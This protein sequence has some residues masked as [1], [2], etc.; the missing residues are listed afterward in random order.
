MNVM[1]VN[2]YKELL[3]GLN[4][5]VMKSIEGVFNVDEIIDTFTNFY[6]DKMILDITAIRDYQNTDNL[7][8]L[9]MNIN[10][11]NVILLLDDSPETATKSYLSKL[12]SLGIYNFTRNAEGINYLLVH[13]HTYRDVVNIHNLEDLDSVTNENGD[14]IVTSSTSGKMKIIGFKNMTQHAGATTLIYL[15]RKALSASKMVGAIEVNKVDFLYFNDKD[16]VSTTTTELPKELM[17]KQLCD[18]VFVDLNDYDDVSICAE[19]YYLIEPSTIMINK[20]LRKNKSV[21][22]TLKEEK[23]VLNKCVLNSDDVSTFE[24]ETKLKVFATIPPVDDRQENIEA[25]NKFISKMNL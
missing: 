16:L 18:V 5:E 1:V 6:Y 23:V 25:I 7:Q 17:K 9:A 8:K 24:Y 20:M 22:E 13:P 21:L 2:K 4:I 19:V 12:I 14:T 15:L 10:M 11:E 3:M